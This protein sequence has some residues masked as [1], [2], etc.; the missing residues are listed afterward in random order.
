MLISNDKCISSTL[1][2]NNTSFFSVAVDLNVY[3]VYL[4]DDLENTSKWANHWEMAFDLDIRKQA[5]EVLFS[6]ENYKISRSPDF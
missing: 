4:N 3:M 2:T 6:Q 1:F 5:Q